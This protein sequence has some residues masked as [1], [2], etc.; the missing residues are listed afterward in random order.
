MV[1]YLISISRS[2]QPQPS[3]PT[4]VNTRFS[5]VVVVVMLAGS[6]KLVGGA[7]AHAPPHYL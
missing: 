1:D 2:K 6:A 7:G 5:R 4:R 3:L